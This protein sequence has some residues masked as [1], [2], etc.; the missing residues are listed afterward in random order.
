VVVELAVVVALVL[1]VDVAFAPPAALLVVP[2]PATVLVDVVTELAVRPPVPAA[3]APSPPWPATSIE[4]PVAHAA[5]A[6]HDVAS[7]MIT[8]AEGAALR[9][10]TKPGYPGGLRAPSV[11]R[12]EFVDRKSR[13]LMV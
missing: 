10:H 5:T 7:A 8:Q 2:G 1:V 13:R 4:V 11:R 9:R 3:P 6:A 12:V